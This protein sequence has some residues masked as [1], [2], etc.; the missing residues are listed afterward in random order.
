MPK[1]SEAQKQALQELTIQWEHKYLSIPALMGGVG[2]GKTE[3]A[4]E[5]AISMGERMN[6]ALLFEPIAAGEASDPTDTSGIPWV[7]QVDAPSDL[8]K[9][10]YRVL[11]ALNRAA[12]Q[13]C[14]VPTLLLFDDIDKATNIVVNSLLNLFVHRRFK[15]FS[16]HPNSLLMTA[17]NRPQDDTH[18]NRMSESMLTRM[19]IIEVEADYEDFCRYARRTGHIHPHLIGFLGARPELL[20]KHEE[21]VYRFPTPRG[22]REA[23]MHMWK[24]PD[25]EWPDIIERKLGRHVR[26]DFLAWYKI[27]SKVDVDHI[28][29]HGTI[30]DMPTNIVEAKMTEFAAVFALTM[31]LNRKNEVRPGWAGID[32]FIDNLRQSPELKIAFL[33][34]LH[35]GARM[36]FRKHYPKSAGKIMAEI[37]ADPDTG[38]MSAGQ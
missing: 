25:D 10:D 33:L 7:I 18:A 5:L 24:Y 35:D 31:R 37:I 30:R 4:A 23:S 29:Q 1:Y 2:I 11:W 19:T 22:Y 38:S 8:T 26:A 16:L 14:H 15:D 32:T 34:Q 6:D 20:H 28:L 17:G 27:L 3:M 13:A 36:A 9:K 21:N 12:Y